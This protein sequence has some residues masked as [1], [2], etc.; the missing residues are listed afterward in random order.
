MKRFLNQKGVTLIEIIA[1]L[2]LVSI[3]TAGAGMGIVAITQGYLF[4][5]KNAEM[6][7]KTNIAIK[8]LSREL[9]ELVSV[10]AFDAN[11]IT[12][13]SLT[14]T[15]SFGF[16]DQAIKLSENG[17]P[18][19]NGDILIDEI[20]AFT[21]SMKNNAGNPWLMGDSLQDLTGITFTLT[22]LR[23]DMPTGNMDFS[24]TIFIRNN[25]NTGGEI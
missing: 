2:V 25:K 8:R 24:T 13:L 10:S 23:P 12:F 6:A 14:G 3:L 21:L 20:G 17:T 19:A 11:S 15:R 7:Q 9:Q 1:V 5:E 18:V 22:I 16:H 4:A